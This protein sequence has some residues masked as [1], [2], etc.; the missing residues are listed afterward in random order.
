MHAVEPLLLAGSVLVLAGVLASKLAARLGVPSLLLFLAVGMAAGSD[1]PGGIRFDDTEL[2]QAVGVVALALILFDG[3]LSTRWS[4]VRPAVGQS[5]VLATVGLA[6]T[7]TI[8]GLTAAWVFDVPAQV[9]LLLGAIVSSTDAAAVFSVLGSRRTR[10]RGTIQPTLELESGLNDPIAVFLTLGLV[11]LATGETSSVWALLPMFGLQLGAGAGIG[12]LGGWLGR[13]LV[14]KTRLDHDGLYPVL[15]LAVVIGTY[16]GAVLVGGSGFLAVYLAGL[17]LGNGE[18]LHRRSILRF[19][20]AVAWLA[21]IGMFLV[22]GLLVFPSRLPEVAGRSV[23][24]VLVL[25]L[26]ARPLATLA[27]LTPFRVPVRDQAV[28]AWVGLRGATPIVLAT[29]PLVQGLPQAQLLFDAVFFVVVVSVLIQGTTVGA[30]AKLLGAT[31]AASARAPAPLEA[32][33]PLADGTS[34]R[35]LVVTG[36]SFA[37]G[38]A[39]VELSLPDR[40]LI[41]LVQRDGA[42]IVPT[43]ATRLAA[44]DT[45]LVLADQ[46]AFAAARLRLQGP[47]PGTGPG[48]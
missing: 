27:S 47:G 25:V 10:L 5:A 6:I 36:G 15:M 30:V 43:G 39:L 45:V 40:A 48:Q 9:G 12:L 11:E 22:L 1:G 28:V 35:E 3:G 23:V 37:A 19:Q 13:T 44:S 34:L 38:R 33:E 41:V 24:V 7:A 21:Q 14:N 17:W 29:F 4:E 46:E 26:L 16:A 32:G 20:E 31:S 2:A 42:S 18:L 8:T